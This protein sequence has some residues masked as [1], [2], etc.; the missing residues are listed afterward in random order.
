MKN[1]VKT[2]AFAALVTGLVAPVL[3][4]GQIT[5]PTGL[6]QTEGQFLGI[7]TRLLNYAFAGLVIISVFLMLWAAYK[8]M[9]GDDK[10]A[11][12][13]IINAAIALAIGLLARG[14][15]YLVNAII[16][17]QYTPPQF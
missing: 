15:P 9:T 10:G 6:P 17:V 16:G 4:F 7:V 3:S 2:V 11:K 1:I 14:L 8:Y 13:Q 5:G 12:T